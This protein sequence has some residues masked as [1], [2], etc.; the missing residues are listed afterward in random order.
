M[1]G[2]S[3]HVSEFN[4]S[5][6]PKRQLSGCATTAF[7]ERCLSLFFLEWAMFETYVAVL[8]SIT[9]FFHAIYEIKWK[10]YIVEPDR[11]Q[12]TVRLMRFACWITRATHTHS[13]YVFFPHCN[14]G[15]VAR[16][17][18]MFKLWATCYTKKKHWLWKGQ[19]EDGQMEIIGKL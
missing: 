5:V 18:C 12:M 6:N 13:E 9:F 3:C 8:C 7:N 17:L 19:L 14:N 2:C 15:Y 11:T 10:K 16:T 1:V 4:Q